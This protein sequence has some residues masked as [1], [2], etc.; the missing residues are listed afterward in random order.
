M[1]TRT[2]GTKDS[3]YKVKVKV[4]DDDEIFLSEKGENLFIFN[5]K[6]SLVS[7][8]TAQ[9]SRISGKENEQSGIILSGNSSAPVLFAQVEQK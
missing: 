4:V 5:D 8:V 6:K 1:I 2:I 7:D 3:N 9:I